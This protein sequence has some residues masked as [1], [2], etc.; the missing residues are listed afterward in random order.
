VCPRFANFLELPS[1]LRAKDCVP[2]P[3]SGQAALGRLYSVIYAFDLVL[4]D[5]GLPCSTP[6][7]SPRL[8]LGNR[9]P[10]LPCTTRLDFVRCLDSRPVVGALGPR[11][12]AFRSGVASFLSSPTFFL[13]WTV[14]GVVNW[15]RPS[16]FAFDALLFSLKHRL[17]SWL[18]LRTRLRLG[19]LPYTLPSP[20]LAVIP[21]A[22]CFFF[23]LCCFGE[24]L[25]S[26]PF[27]GLG[28]FKCLCAVLAFVG[29]AR[30]PLFSL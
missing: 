11:V 18:C 22:V 28:V 23:S 14:E 6:L 4:G 10:N 20:V 7:F 30:F 2:P 16:C 24:R 26:F 17:R 19:L 3:P 8:P 1:T 15:G 29:G 21:I 5:Q 9:L 12:I 25:L 13:N 27:P